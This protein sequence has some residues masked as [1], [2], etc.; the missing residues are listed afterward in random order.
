MIR[1]RI[2]HDEEGRRSGFV[3][4]GHALTAP[5]GSDV[6]CAAVSMLLQSVLLGLDQ[7]ADVHPRWERKDGLLRCEVPRAALERESVRVL[8]DTM[9]MA[10]VN[11]AAQ[12]P[13]AIRIEEKRVRSR[14][15]SRQSES[16]T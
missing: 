9:H 3:A 16:S 15:G 13:D 4:R 11:V 12:H 6:V 7:V 2:T 1:I 14:S 10:L 8:M 5:H